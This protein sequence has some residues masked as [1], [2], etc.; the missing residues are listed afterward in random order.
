[1]SERGHR[2][3]GRWRVGLVAVA[4]AVAGSCS[5]P[6]NTDMRQWTD[7]LTF[8][9]SNDPT[10]PR[11]RERITYKVVVR[12]KGSG[13]PIEK[14]EGRIFATSKDGANSWDSFEPGP[15]PGTYYANMKFIT[16]GAWA[17]ALQFRR[18]ST[19]KLERVDWMQEVRAA[20]QGN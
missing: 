20:R 5:S 12:D 16:A 19:Q 10:P 18:D 15:E 9:I 11:A 4:T 13:Q 8:R 7:D 2:H 1:M 6:P 3:L 17:V 14:G